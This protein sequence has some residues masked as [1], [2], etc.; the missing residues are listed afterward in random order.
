M[1]REAV[2]LIPDDPAGRYTYGRLLA[3]V[4]RDDLA[5]PQLAEAIRL[6][7][8]P[9][10]YLDACV[11]LAEARLRLGDP[12]GAAAILDEAGGLAWRHRHLAAIALARAG[13][14]VDARKRLPLRVGTGQFIDVAPGLHRLGRA[15][16]ARALLRV[17]L[18]ADPE[19]LDPVPDNVLPKPPDLSWAYE[20]GLGDL[21]AS[22]LRAGKTGGSVASDG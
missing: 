20:A 17:A 1:A 16:D 11:A 9:V 21:I 5:A 2:H 18:M 10:R 14:L 7:P 4:G 12:S 6:K 13:R 3:W 22:A 19:M 8:D 15:D